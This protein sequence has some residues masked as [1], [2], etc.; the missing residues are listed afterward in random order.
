MNEIK[1][2]SKAI[3]LLLKK[4]VESNSLEWNNIL[5][6]Q[7]DIQ[8]YLSVIG[9]EL[10]IKKDEGFAYV[11]QIVMEDDSTLSLVQRRQLTFEVS[12]ILVVLRQLLEDFD[13]NPTDT[14]STERFVS[15]NEIKDEVRLFLPEK[16]N[17]AKLE[18]DLDTH[19]QS[20]VKLGF[21]KE[22]WNGN[23]DTRYVIHRIIKEKV[24]LDDLD[25]F[26]Q[27]LAEYV[28]GTR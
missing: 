25:L 5:R 15:A 21:L 24:T 26:R 6:Y 10:V 14:H 27:K 4:T 18:K 16:Y 28:G 22:V 13:N 3:V 23:N 8:E 20:V 9:L 12:V 7:S 11:K 1:P 19:I 2:Y 17:K